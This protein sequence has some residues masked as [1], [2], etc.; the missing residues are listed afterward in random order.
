MDFPLPWSH[1]AAFSFFLFTGKYRPDTWPFAPPY[2]LT[3]VL[4]RGLL[5][6]STAIAMS[7]D[8]PVENMFSARVQ[9]ICS[10]LRGTM[11]ELVAATLHK[12]P[13]SPSLQQSSE[14]AGLPSPEQSTGPPRCRKVLL[15]AWAPANT[16]DEHFCSCCTREL[17]C[18]QKLPSKSVTKKT[19]YIENA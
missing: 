17:R 2:A 9:W 4:Q 14:G 3:T 11:H 5:Q 16:A 15:P 8:L 12:L 6:L 18:I 13:N 7:K 10:H 1:S 19:L